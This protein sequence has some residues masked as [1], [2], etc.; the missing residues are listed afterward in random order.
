MSKNGKSVK[1][2]LCNRV[3]HPRKTRSGGFMNAMEVLREHWERFHG[4]EHE[5]MQE[6]LRE[7]LPDFIPT[8]Y[9]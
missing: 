3:F 6:R 4:E 7:Q 9:L 1:C 5:E 2:R 8:D